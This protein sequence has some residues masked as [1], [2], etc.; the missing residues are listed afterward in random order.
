MPA[1]RGALPAELYE[2]AFTGGCCVRGWMLPSFRRLWT[3]VL[4]VPVAASF[5][6]RILDEHPFKELFLQAVPVMPTHRVGR[7]PMIARR[8]LMLPNAI[9][10]SDAAS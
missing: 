8:L 1:W 9:N 10:G 3:N 5:H 2:G 6:A 7:R 4:E